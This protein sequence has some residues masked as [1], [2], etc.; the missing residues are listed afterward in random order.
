CKTRL[1]EV[2]QLL[3]GE[4]PGTSPD[5]EEIQAI[6]RQLLSRSTVKTEVVRQLAPLAERYN[7][8]RT[9][10]AMANLRLVAHVAR[11]YRNRG[12]T[13]SDLLQEGFCG[14][15][16]AIVRFEPARETRLASYAVWWI[17]QALQRAV[18]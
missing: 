13:S 15:R 5:A 12:I 17:R 18:A 1:L 6:V 11:E 10:L 16:K 8:L 7:E 4:L 9:K 3:G 2:R 14:L